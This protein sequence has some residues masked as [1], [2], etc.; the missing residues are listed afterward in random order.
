MNQSLRSCLKTAITSLERE[1][2]S[3]YGCLRK[4]ELGS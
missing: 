1:Y 3:V 2:R 4:T